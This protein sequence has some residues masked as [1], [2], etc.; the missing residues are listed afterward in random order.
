MSLLVLVLSSMWTILLRLFVERAAVEDA[1]VVEN[2]VAVE[3]RFDS[4]FGV[5][6]EIHS[7]V[8]SLSPR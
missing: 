3:K 6:G 7:Y 2:A 5:G 8:S 4:S 1:G